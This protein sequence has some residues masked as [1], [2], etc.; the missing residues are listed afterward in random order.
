M[1]EI[2]KRSIQKSSSCA[3]VGAGSAGRKK[4]N[5]CI[6]SEKMQQ[7]IYETLRACV[8]VCV[9]GCLL[10][11]HQVHDCS[12]GLMQRRG[13]RYGAG[14]AGLHWQQKQ[15][16]NCIH[17][18]KNTHTHTHTAGTRTHALNAFL[19]KLHSTSHTHTRTHTQI[20]PWC[21]AL[22]TR[23]RRATPPLK[24]I[25]PSLLPAYDNGK[26]SPSTLQKIAAK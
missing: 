19:T 24:A 5:E 21:G 22:C 15:T 23:C 9:G 3:D 26:F 2:E 16:C 14:Q 4:I 25:P 18:K 6:S 17:T 1:S 11:T 8:C 7:H 20:K 12:S 10:R 13:K